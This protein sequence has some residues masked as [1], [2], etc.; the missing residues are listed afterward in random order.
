MTFFNPL[1]PL[2]IAGSDSSDEAAAEPPELICS[3]RKCRND[4]VW[5]LRW[6]NP[7]VHTP[8]RRKIWLACQDHLESLTDFLEDR[9][10]LKDVVPV[11][12]LQDE[13]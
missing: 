8:D 5:A 12:D 9:G 1:D 6:N 13:A 4:S 3:A 10:Y 11:A 7:R 2:G